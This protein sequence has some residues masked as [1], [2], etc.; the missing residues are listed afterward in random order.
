VP[1][2]RILASGYLRVILVTHKFSPVASAYRAAVA[3]SDGWIAKIAL[4]PA[5]LW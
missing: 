5:F 1:I 3:D 4:Q 2:D